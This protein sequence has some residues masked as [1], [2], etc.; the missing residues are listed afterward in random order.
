MRKISFAA[1]MVVFPAQRNSAVYHRLGEVPACRTV[2]D[3]N[4]NP[5]MAGPA[6]VAGRAGEG[7]EVAR[8]RPQEASARGRG[9]G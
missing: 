8:E 1:V 5:N 7:R 6:V 4:L 9:D 3:P 2:D